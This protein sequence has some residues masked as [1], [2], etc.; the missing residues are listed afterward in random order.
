MFLSSSLVGYCFCL[1]ITHQRIVIYEG[2][3]CCVRTA[4]A[5]ISVLLLLGVGFAST[6]RGLLQVPNGAASVIGAVL[7]GRG[8]NKLRLL[9]Y[10]IGVCS[11]PTNLI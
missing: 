5:L 7:K 2:N 6:Q 1:R 10:S 9:A 4:A 3:V 8:E 11:T